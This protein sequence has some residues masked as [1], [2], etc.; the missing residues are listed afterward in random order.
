[1]TK[2]REARLR[3][4]HM[5]HGGSG[6]CNVCYLLA[7]NDRLRAEFNAEQ[8]EYAKLKVQRD[9]LRAALEIIG[10]AADGPCPSC[11]S[12]E[13]ACKALEK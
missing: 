7:E 8:V 2:E 13:I 12:D 4:V 6:S 10:Y 5:A 11:R 1:M 3:S 9:R